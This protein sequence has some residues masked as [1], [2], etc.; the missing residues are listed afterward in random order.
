MTLSKITTVETRSES[1]GC[2]Q[3]A[4]GTLSN[5]LQFM[6]GLLCISLPRESYASMRV[7]AT[8]PLPTPTQEVVNSIHESNRYWHEIHRNKLIT[9][10]QLGWSPELINE[11]LKG[12]AAVRVQAHCAEVITAL[13]FVVLPPEVEAGD[14]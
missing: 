12:V 7:R 6:V 4:G 11:H 8:T 9:L 13:G 10:K 2:I 14:Q 5:A 3:W 1:H